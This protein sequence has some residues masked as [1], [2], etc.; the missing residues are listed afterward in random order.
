MK[1]TGIDDFDAQFRT[2]LNKL[3]PEIADAAESA[4]KESEEV[5]KRH[6]WEDV[7]SES[8]YS[9]KVYERRSDNP[10]LGTPLDNMAENVV[11]IKPTGGNAGGQLQLTAKL[12]YRPQGGHKVKKWN[13]ASYDAL[14]GRIEKK[15]PAYTYDNGGIPPRPFWQN[16]VKE[17]VENGEL[18]Q[19]FVRALKT[20][21]EVVADGAITPDASDTEY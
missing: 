9:P 3:V 10:S 14:I 12:Y 20:K 8:V 7:Y 15:S 21:E 2:F 4:M 11:L 19:A 1:W 17:M 6:I 16:F 13:T 5:L 18:E